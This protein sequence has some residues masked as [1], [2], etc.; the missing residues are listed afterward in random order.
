[1]E[2]I[3]KVNKF[4]EENIILSIILE[5]DNFDDIKKI[6]NDLGFKTPSKMIKYLINKEMVLQNKFINTEK[7][8]LINML[9]ASL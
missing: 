1:M 9:V 2:K 5:K 7:S 4:R 6:T 8:K 3:K